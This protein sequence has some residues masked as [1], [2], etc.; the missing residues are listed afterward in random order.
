MASI[1]LFTG[2]IRPLPETGRPTGMYKMPVV[3]PVALGPEGFAGDQQ[4]DRRVHGGPDKAVHLYPARHYARLAARFPEAAAQ[5]VP[6]SLGENLSTPDLDEGD[7]R[8]GD[9]WQL[10]SALLQVSQ[11][12]N[13]CWKIDERFGADGMAGFIAEHLL[14]GWYWRVVQPGYVSPGDTLD[15]LHAAADTPTLR[16]AQLL[17]QAHRPAVADLERLADLPGLARAWRDKIVQRLSWLKKSG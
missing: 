5:L 17:W 10:G 14:T 8:I 15:L 3:R 13:P 16:E 2:G 11:P 1:A 4:A 7:V 12:R 6:G 9:L